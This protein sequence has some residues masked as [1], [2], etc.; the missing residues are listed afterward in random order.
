[1][2]KQAIKKAKAPV[3][4]P[5]KKLK[6]LKERKK[7]LLLRLD[8]QQIKL[9]ALKD[10]IKTL[11]RSHPNAFLY[12]TLEQHKVLCEEI[13]DLL[14]QSIKHKNL[15][16]TQRQDLK[17]MLKDMQA[18][19]KEE[20]QALEEI[21]QDEE[22]NPFSN[23]TDEEI[24]R[25]RES[26]QEKPSLEKA[27]NALAPSASPEEKKNIRALYLELVK[28]C[29]PDK[30]SSEDQIKYHDL[31]QEINNA[32]HS[33]DF[34]RLLQIKTNIINFENPSLTETAEE[35]QIREIETLQLEIG[36]LENN[37]ERL[38]TEISNIQKSEFGLALKD[39][40]K[41]KESFFNDTEEF[42]E[43]LY[44]LK[45][46]LEDFLETG[47]LPEELLEKEEVL[48]L[49]ELDEEEVMYA[50]QMLMQMLNKTQKN[51]K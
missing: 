8:K 49:D 7:L 29:H 47:I 12:E 31:M 43:E 39:I 1:M 16:K 5:E 38:K 45:R 3:N 20:E 30:H 37:L 48:S 6:K 2:S 15:T 46:G 36:L 32:Y 11:G 34:N 19:L 18:Q 25:L 13:C 33:D 9:E 10:E 50:M 42:I 22:F 28:Q 27:L 24:Q 17:K 4:A 44:T 35:K 51:K 14:K 40:K 23:L 21:L 41:M 26:Q